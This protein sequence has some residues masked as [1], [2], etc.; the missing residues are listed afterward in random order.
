M[1]LCVRKRMARNAEGVRISG[2]DASWTCNTDRIS[3]LVLLVFDFV[4]SGFH[5]SDF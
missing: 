5:P 3:G 4:K 2:F 1:D